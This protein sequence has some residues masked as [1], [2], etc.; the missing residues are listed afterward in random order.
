MSEEGA[1]C[2]IVFLSP[3]VIADTGSGT[4]PLHIFNHIV[5][6]FIASY[7]QILN[8]LKVYCKNDW[9][10]QLFYFLSVQVWCLRGFP[11]AHD[12]SVS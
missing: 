1:C 12:R 10:E 11:E 8:T 3:K 4:I 2:K 6:T 9:I 5:L 7:L